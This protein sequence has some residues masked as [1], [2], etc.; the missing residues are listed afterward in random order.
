MFQGLVSEVIGLLVAGIRGLG[1]LL[2]V[3]FGALFAIRLEVESPV[4]CVVLCVAVTA[5]AVIGFLALTRA[6]SR[7][8]PRPGRPD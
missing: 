8:R 1:L 2:L 5:L 6:R 3:L 4:L 7:Q